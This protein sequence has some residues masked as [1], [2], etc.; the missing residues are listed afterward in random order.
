MVL[1]CILVGILAGCQ[2]SSTNNEPTLPTVSLENV[3]TSDELYSVALS[4]EQNKKNYNLQES[5]RDDNLWYYVYYLGR[6]SGVPIGNITANWYKYDGK[7]ESTQVF[8]ISEMTTETVSKSF[9]ESNSLTDSWTKELTGSA[10]TGLSNTVSAEVK[11]SASVDAGFASA[12]VEASTGVSVEQTLEFGLEEKFGI[13]SSKGSTLSQ[14]NE[15]SKATTLVT[16]KT[17]S[18]TFA[19]DI[20]PSGYY[21]YVTLGVADVFGLV[22]FNPDKAEATIT[23]FSN[24]VF[25]YDEMVY[26]VDEFS[27]DLTENSKLELPLD[28]LDF[29]KPETYY[30]SVNVDDILPEPDEGQVNLPQGNGTKENPYIIR[31]VEDFESCMSKNNENVWFKLVNNI[32]FAGENYRNNYIE[33]FKGIL[34]GDGYSIKNYKNTNINSENAGFFGRVCASAR[35][36]NVKFENCTFSEITNTASNTLNVG[37]VCGINEGTIHNVLVNNCSFEKI[38]FGSK[39]SMVVNSGYAGYICGQSLENS[40]VERCGVENGALNLKVVSKGKDSVAYA[41]GIV[42]QAFCEISD[43]YSRQNTISTYALANI[44][45]EV[46]NKWGDAYS[47]VGGLVGNLKSS[48]RLFDSIVYKNQITSSA[49]GL[50]VW[51]QNAGKNAFCPKHNDTVSNCYEQKGY[52]SSFKNNIWTNNSSGEAIINY[53]WKD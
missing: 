5:F 4:S 48:G 36:E 12:G 14:L 30:G 18:F 10:K 49:K 29:S 6:V 33:E 9:E 20:T 45:T 42:G 31:T 38:E 51:N 24:W 44:K 2:T 46:F 3:S 7:I 34:V 37:V 23:S 32:D 43:C 35:I 50:Y 19:P 25:L 40:K 53:T 17:M 21:N 39:T 52:H 41:G 22:I 1:C 16:E 26:S 13:N 11:A 28:E 15:S 8:T 27:V 47:Y